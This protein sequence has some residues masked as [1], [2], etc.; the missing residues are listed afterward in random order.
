MA[1]ETSSAIDNARMKL[2]CSHGGGLVPCAPD[3]ALRYVGGKTRVISVPRSVSFRDLAAKLSEM[4]GGAVVR[5]VKHRLA[6]TGLEDV[7]VSVTSDDELAHMRD[8][9]DRM[10]TTRPNTAFRVFLSGDA[11]GAHQTSGVR[12]PTFG[13]E[14][15][16]RAERAGARRARTAAASSSHLSSAADPAGPERAVLLQPPVPP[17]AAVFLLPRRARSRGADAGSTA[18]EHRALHVQER[19]RRAVWKPRTRSCGEESRSGSLHP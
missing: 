13:A 16:A 12:A 11:S 17:P 2:M 1:A 3:G 6:D 9:Y 4:A 7:I 5:A 18:D 19:Q 10:R 14:D 15:A 8:E